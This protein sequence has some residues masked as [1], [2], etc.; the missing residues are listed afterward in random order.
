MTLRKIRK[1]ETMK[2]TVNSLL[3]STNLTVDSFDDTK[4]DN[5]YIKRMIQNVHHHRSFTQWTTL[6]R[7]Q[8]HVSWLVQRDTIAAQA[9]CLTV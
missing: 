8:T 3:G 6:L 2:R 9:D 7:K 1:N 5:H 4:L